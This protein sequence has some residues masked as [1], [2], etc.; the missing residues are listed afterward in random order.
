MTLVLEIEYL[1]GVSFA[2]VGPD[3]EVPEWPPRPD[4]IFSAL[5]ASWAARG[6]LEEERRALEWL[7]M[8]SVPRLF[9]SEAE[10]RPGVTVFVPAND[11]SS[12]KQKHAKNVL[13]ALR[14]RQ[15]R[16]YGFPAARPHDCRKERRLAR[17]P[18]SA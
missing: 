9:A 12:D 8:L 16:E 14:N 6:E 13:P 10:P 3:S 11:P 2:A 1:P 17:H 7:E 18:S 5:V 15:A 4:R